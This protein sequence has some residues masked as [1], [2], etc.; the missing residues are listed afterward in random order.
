[1]N[2][3]GWRTT[4]RCIHRFLVFMVSGYFMW[5]CFKTLHR[6]HVLLK[7]GTYQSLH[8]WQIY[9]LSTTVKLYSNK[10]PMEILTG[11]SISFVRSFM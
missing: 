2:R 10:T 5:D 9:S 6:A 7:E 1:M 11:I 8:Q 4:Q 3:I